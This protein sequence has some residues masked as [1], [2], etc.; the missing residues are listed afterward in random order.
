MDLKEKVCLV[1]GGTSGIGAA[2][3]IALSQRGAHIA[4]VSRRAVTAAFK[5]P[6]EMHE[7]MQNSWFM[8]GFGSSAIFRRS[9][10]RSHNR[11]SSYAR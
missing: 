8:S 6:C 5:L 7:R 3:A 9:R 2:T 1:T 4:A 11:T 10:I